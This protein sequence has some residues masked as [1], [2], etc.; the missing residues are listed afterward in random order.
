[1]IPARVG[2][3][4]WFDGLPG[5]DPSIK[6]FSHEYGKEVKGENERE[7]VIRPKKK[8]RRRSRVINNQ[9]KTTKG[10]GHEKQQ[11]GDK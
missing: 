8:M 9:E 1:M 7:E 3:G 6:R 5:V 11:K 2:A 10:I 4:I